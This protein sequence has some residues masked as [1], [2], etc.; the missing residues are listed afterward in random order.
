MSE[1]KET[2]K[3]KAPVVLK[4]RKK[5]KFKRQES[6]RYRRVKE[7]WRKARGLDSKMRK[8]V[9]GWPPSPNKGYRN[10]KDVRGLHPS[11][12][13]EVRVVGIHDLEKIDPESEAIKIG[14]TVGEKKRTQIVNTARE[15]GIYVLNPREMKELE[16]ERET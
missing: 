15:M 14:H 7:S 3:R 5:P 9:K 2:S 1:E 12:F 10:Q 6:W 8:N 16:E 11:G 13:R 4:K